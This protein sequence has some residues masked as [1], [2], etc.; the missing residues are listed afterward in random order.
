MNSLDKESQCWFTSGQR[1]DL[2]NCETIQAIL[3]HYRNG[4]K[5]Q[6]KRKTF[7]SNWVDIHDCPTNF[8]NFYFRI[9]Q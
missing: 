7:G 5:L 8:A 9:K 3:Q 1:T 2:E 6:A 4:E